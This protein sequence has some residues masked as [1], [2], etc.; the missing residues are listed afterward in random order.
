MNAIPL[1]DLKIQHEQISD[2]VEKGFARVFSDTS[3]ILGTDV[4]EFEDQFARFSGVRHCVGV[5]SGTDALELIIRAAGIGQGDE[6]ILPTN[7]FIATALAVVRAGATPVLVDCDADY[8]LIDVSEVE[9]QLSARTRA[10]IPVHLYGQMAP[11]EKLEA[12]AKRAGVVLLEDAAQAQGASQNG[13]RAGTIGL[14]AGTSFFPSKNI[15]AYG[16][17]GAVL[18]NDGRIAEKIRRLRNWGSDRRYYH[19]DAGFNSRLDTLQAVVLKA[20]LSHLANWNE[21]RREAAA[22]YD[23]LLEGLDWV[24]RPRTLRGNEHIWHLYVVRVPRRDAVLESLQQAGIGVGIHYPIP[25]HL[26][27]AFGSLGLGRGSFPISEKAADEVLSLPLFPG[28]TEEQQVR[29]V[30]EF[31]R[32]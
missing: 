28:I 4:A 11:M 30:D 7:T 9:A 18:T 21:L 31:A 10:I 32:C 6:V 13:Q 1:V 5:G 25:I 22:R 19:P 16:D 15:G 23:R 24:V 12:L 27:G 20:K 14:A 2:E 26:S 17:G 8:R 29:I 3:F